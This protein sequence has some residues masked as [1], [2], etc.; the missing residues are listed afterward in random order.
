MNFFTIAS[1]D[2]SYYYLATLYG[3]V[4]S[5]L[6]APSANPLLGVMFKSLNTTALILG[7]ILV[8]HTTVVGLLKTAAEGEFLGRQWSSLWV[9]LRMVMGIASLF[10][11][12]AGY[13]ALQIILMWIIL[14]GVGAADQ[15]WNVVLKDISVMGSPYT[16]ASTTSTASSGVSMSGLFQQIVCDTAAKSTYTDTYPDPNG[17]TT[18]LNY[19]YC[20]GQPATNAYCTQDSLSTIL[21]AIAPTS[22]IPTQY[23]QICFKQTSKDNGDTITCNIGPAAACGTLTFA[24]YKNV[25]NSPLV[26]GGGTGAASAENAALTAQIDCANRKAQQN[27][28]ARSVVPNLETTAKALVLQDEQ[29]LKFYFTNVPTPSPSR[30]LPNF[31]SRYCNDHDLTV[32]KCCIY[33]P[34]SSSFSATDVAPI[35]P[36]CMTKDAFPLSSNIVS[37]GATD[38]TNLNTESGLKELFW[39]CG[40]APF[41]TGDTS[42][43]CLKSPGDAADFISTNKKYYLDYLS[44]ATSQAYADYINSQP[45]NS[46]SGW[47]QEASNTGWILAGAYYYR[48]AKQNNKNQ[49]VVSALPFFPTSSTSALSSSVLGS[50]RTNYSASSALTTLIAGQSSGPSSTPEL[51]GFSGPMMGV[52]GDIITSFMNTLTGGSDYDIATNPLTRI[53]HL[54]EVLMISGQVIFPVFLVIA[55]PLLLV[56][57]INVTAL[58]TGLTDSPASNLTMFIATSIFSLVALF[59]AWCFT[60][61]ALLGVYTPFI[62]YIFFTFGTIG[63]FIATVEAMVAAP[64]VALGILSPGGQSEILGRADPGVMIIMNTFLRPSL[65]IMGMMA[66]MLLAP[67]IVTLI[68]SGI[69]GVMGDIFT[70]GIGIIEMIAFL[71]LYTMLVLTALNKCFALIHMIP[72]RVLTWIGGQAISYGEGESTQAVKGGFESASSAVGGGAR[73][74]SEARVGMA[75]AANKDLEKKKPEKKDAENPEVAADKPPQNQPPV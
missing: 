42:T 65:M 28:L 8:T 13:S 46:L 43:S 67:I 45:I 64:F 4:G 10:P 31:I 60:F 29:Y 73:G 39:P 74:V 35:T 72:E 71:A 30:S 38:Y 55:L 27:I 58:G 7:A 3:N 11:T 70:N 75:A 56:G 48:I 68:N 53:Q 41:I 34:P 54:G 40:I 57:K 69:K 59:C 51:S 1:N 9:P 33:T 63:W 17:G 15:L 19:Y 2:Q 6:T 44:S 36:S 52:G 16:K 66:A 5:V 50:Y 12:G 20:A 47:E 18:P 22:E 49:G 37:G 14:Q 24:D 23:S 32:N 62:P 61:G 26:T 25:C 21:Q